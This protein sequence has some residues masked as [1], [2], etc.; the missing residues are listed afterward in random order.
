MLFSRSG[1]LPTSLAIRFSLEA[2][3]KVTILPAT[4]WSLCEDG[5]TVRNELATAILALTAEKELPREV[6]INA[7]EEALAQTYRRQYGTVPE[8]RVSMDLETGQFRV[9]GKKTVV[10]NV[11]DPRTQISL[12]DAQNLPDPGGLGDI[13]EVD[14]TPSDFSRIGAQA[15]K[16]AIL[17]RIHEAERDLIYNEY[18]NK[19]GELLTG[20]VQRVEPRGIIVDL[21]RAEGLLPPSEQ[22]PRERYR[23]GQ[24]LKVYVVEVSRGTRA[25]SII[26]SRSHKNLVKRLFEMEVPEVFNGVVE[27]KAIAREPG[28]RSKMAVAARQPGI[29][30]VGA[31]V[32]LRGVRIQN[33]VNELNNEKIDVILYSDDPAQ[34]VANA[35]SPATVTSVTIDRHEKRAEVVVPEEILSLAIGKEGQNARLAAKLTGWRIDI[36]GTA[37]HHVPSSE[38][39]DAAIQSSEPETPMGVQS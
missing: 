33:V 39:E 18:A 20:V 2:G 9:L 17:Q 8:V 36:R 31:C 26:L 10:I 14:V 6:V 37:A 34:F 32:G 5:V 12:K 15:A 25:P 27:I 16:Q 23:I 22:V 30:P 35:L 3:H 28:S 1:Q 4:L 38:I 7:V 19:E 21:G 13:V 11:K 29:D 24:R